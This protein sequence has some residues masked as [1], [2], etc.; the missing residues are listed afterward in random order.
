MDYRPGNQHIASNILELPLVHLSN[1]IEHLESV[2]P[3]EGCGI[4]G[5]RG[6]LVQ[7]FFPITK[8]CHSPVSYRMDAQEQ[9]DAM[10]S[11]EN[12]DMEMLSI[13][14]SHPTGP[15]EP[16]EKDLAEYHYPDVVSLIGCMHE[17]KWMF[18]C[19]MI[20]GFDFLEIELRLC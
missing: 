11:L 6:N 5:G 4:L 16:S 10:I 19:F 7:A 8:I 1:L 18:R 12:Q 15:C 3:E 13:F 20:N 9:L 2:F 14:H 17:S